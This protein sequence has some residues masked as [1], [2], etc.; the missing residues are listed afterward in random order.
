M[1]FC[2]LAMQSPREVAMFEFFVF[3]VVLFGFWAFASHLS[4]GAADRSAKHWSPFGNVELRPKT[5]PPKGQIRRKLG[6]VDAA[7]LRT[8][9]KSAEKSQEI[10]TGTVIWKG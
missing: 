8:T 10:P 1:L 9:G 4:R 7:V 5:L 3:T 2:T 6:S